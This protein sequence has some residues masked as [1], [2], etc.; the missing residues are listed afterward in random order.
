MPK[1]QEISVKGDETLRLAGQDLDLSSPEIQ[2]RL[3]AMKDGETLTIGRE[4]DIRVFE[5]NTY[6]SRKHLTIRKSG[7]GF[8]IK[9]ISTNGTSLG[10]TLPQINENELVREVGNGGREVNKNYIKLQE[11][12]EHTLTMQLNQDV[13]QQTLKHISKL[14]TKLTKSHTADLTV[15][16]HGINKQ[17]KDTLKSTRVKSVGRVQCATAE[18]KKQA[19]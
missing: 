14:L 10:R 7:D 19:L 3:K 2:A 9:D 5:D 16:L 12:S 6:V 17:D 13:M 4:G 8:V 15:N 1:G 18:L 11:N